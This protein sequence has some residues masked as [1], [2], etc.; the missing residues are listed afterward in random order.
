M[1]DEMRILYKR[2]FLSQRPLHQSKTMQNHQ[3][4]ERKRLISQIWRQLL[5]LPHPEFDEPDLVELSTKNN[6]EQIFLL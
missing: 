3:F 6:G 5:E 4:S 2:L 1:L